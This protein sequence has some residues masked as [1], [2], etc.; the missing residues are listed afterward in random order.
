[1]T[2]ATVLICA[3]AIGAVACAT[4]AAES[5]RVSLVGRPAA[6][7]VGRAWTVNL[8]V[9]PTAFHGVVLVTAVGP[10]RIDVRASGGHGSYRAR[11][12]FPAAGRWT[13]TAHAGTTTSRL[14]SV[15]VRRGAPTPLT[16]VWPTSV[17]VEPDGSLLL[18]ENGLHRLVRIAP[19][20]GRVTE[21]AALTKPYAVERAPSGSIFVTD[22]PF[23]RRIDG[24]SAPVKVAGADAD[25]GPIAIARNGDVYYATST[26]IWKLRDGT[27]APVRIA[28]QAQLSG[29]HGLAIGADGAILVADTG[30]NR[31]L[32]VDPQSGAVTTFARVAVPR[33]MDVAADGTI[34]VVDGDAN[35][36]LHL[37][38][39][40][41]QLGL[42]GPTFDDPYAVEAAPGGT[43]YVVESLESGDVRRVASDGTVTTVSR[44]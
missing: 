19:A 42:V 12:V 23:L 2:R 43:V 3:A 22:G 35:R 29:P 34:D 27:G 36:V 8:S 37:S 14:G 38:A 41:K 5:I 6:V 1:M 18:V 20:T 32:R 25:I 15:Q 28:E 4:S 44:R 16:F 31:I 24:T 33:G 30:N 11:L 40:G 9:R 26:Q 7:T 21:I 17:A 13:L 39:S 10:R